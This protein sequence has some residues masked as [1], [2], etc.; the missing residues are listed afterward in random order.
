MHVA[1]PGVIFDK[2]V[3]YMVAT[4]DGHAE[5]VFPIHASTNLV[6][7][8][9]VGSVFPHNSRPAWTKAS[10]CKKQITKVY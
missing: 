4:S 8:K 10:Y 1:D 7:W 2:G 6:D 3:Y 9:L 5:N